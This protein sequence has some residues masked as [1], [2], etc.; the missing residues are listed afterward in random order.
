MSILIDENTRV[1]VQ[2]ITGREASFVTRQ[3]LEYGTKVVAGVTPGKG[4]QEVHG[5][6]VYDTVKEAVENHDINTSLIYVPP[7]FAKD[8]VLEAIDNGIK[9]IVIITEHIPVHDAMKLYHYAK[10]KGAR[11]IGPNSVG[12]ITPG[13]VKMGAIGGDNPARAFKPG[14]VGIISRSGG[15][16]TETAWMLKR[17]GFGVS[18]AVSIGGD[19]IIGTTF[20]DLLEL[21]EEDPETEAVVMFGEPGGSFEE[22]AAEFIKEGGFTKPVIAFIA[23]RFM[24][25]MPEGMTFGHAGAIIEGGTGT[26][27]QKMKRLKE[28]GVHVA[29]SHHEI[30]PLVKEVL[31][32][33][34]LR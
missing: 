9:L 8:A 24:E 13:K 31:G 12:I 5:V 11:I 29:E 34:D 28:A 25:S 18:T 20:A 23:G 14:N 2:G 10:K 17:A 16:T 6:P 32:Q 3:M 33:R 30:I 21:F 1:I 27:S 4:G 22:E 7:A 26:P 15:M 19:A